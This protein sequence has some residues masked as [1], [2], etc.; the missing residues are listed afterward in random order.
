[1][2]EYI[3]KTLE[4]KQVIYLY[5]FVNKNEIDIIVNDTLY[6]FKQKGNKVHLTTEKTSQDF[7]L[8]Y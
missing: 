3:L 2:L 8:K 1:M 6:N 7:K 5:E 4:E